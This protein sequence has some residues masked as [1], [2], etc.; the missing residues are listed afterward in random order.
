MAEPKLLN[1]EWPSP[2]S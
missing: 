2:N 1:S